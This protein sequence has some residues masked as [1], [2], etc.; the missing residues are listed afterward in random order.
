MHDKSLVAEA[1]KNIEENTQEIPK[2]QNTTHLRHKE[3]GRN[4]N[5]KKMTLFE[6]VIPRL[7]HKLT[8]HTGGQTMV[9]LFITLISEDL[10]QYD[11]F[12]A[13]F[14]DFLPG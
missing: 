6:I 14:C 12:R 10:V 8:S 2:S 11:I 3:K 9:Y 5:G 1:C 7:V 13:K 4:A